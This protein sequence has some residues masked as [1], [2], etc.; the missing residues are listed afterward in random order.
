MVGKVTGDKLMYVCVPEEAY[1]ELME[2][3]DSGSFN[4]ICLKASIILKLVCSFM[5]M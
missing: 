4:G 2:D 1:G 5:R 3:D